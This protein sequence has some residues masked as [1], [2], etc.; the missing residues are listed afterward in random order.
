MKTLIAL[1]PVLVLLAVVT[2]AAASGDLRAVGFDVA[3]LGGGR[4]SITVEH[5][6]AW[7][8]DQPNFS[9]SIVVTQRRG[10]QIVAVPYQSDVSISTLDVCDA[11]CSGSCESNSCDYKV[12]PDPTVWGGTC[13]TAPK[14]CPL[15]KPPNERDIDGCTCKR[16][17]AGKFGAFE[18]ML[19][20]GDVISV[21]ITPG[22]SFQDVNTTNN[23]LQFSVL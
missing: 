18:V 11:V 21:T 12:S 23:T 3:A 15:E 13:G 14:M 22:G 16:S 5:D 17:D 8:S 1:V 19:T 10:G 2:P 6:A 20:V 4:Y 9:Y 7:G